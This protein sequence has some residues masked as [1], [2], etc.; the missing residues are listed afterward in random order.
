MDAPLAGY[1][2]YD[3][4][5]HDGHYFIVGP[6]D[7]IHNENVIVFC[8]TTK[9]HNRPNSDGCHA[10]HRL[11]SF[12]LAPGTIPTLTL[13]T[14]VSLDEVYFYAKRDFDT[15]WRY[16]KEKF[17]LSLTIDLLKCASQSTAIM[18]V[19]AK[20]CGNEANLLESAL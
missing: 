2:Y 4:D 1:L 19:D 13:P 18:K 6:D 5:L 8:C 20:A 9:R 11:P 14:W 16:A 12:H 7:P 17:D 3:K 10:N 15:K